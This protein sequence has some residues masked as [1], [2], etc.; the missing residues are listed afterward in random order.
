MYLKEQFH[1]FKWFRG[2]VVIVRWTTKLATRVRSTVATGLSNDFS[3]LGGN[4]SGYCY[5]DYWPRLDNLGGIE[6]HCGLCWKQVVPSIPGGDFRRLPILNK[7]P[8]FT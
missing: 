1:V 7:R 3:V 6:T 8:F 5:Q 2:R 4:P